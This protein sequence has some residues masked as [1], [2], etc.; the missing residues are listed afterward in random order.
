[1]HQMHA[2]VKQYCAWPLVISKKNGPGSLTS[3]FLKLY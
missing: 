2:A 1:M 3:V